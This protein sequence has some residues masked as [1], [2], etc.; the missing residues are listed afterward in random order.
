MLTESCKRL[1]TLAHLENNMGS[2]ASGLI[3]MWRGKD[4][5]TKLDFPVLRRGIFL[6]MLT[7][8]VY[9]TE[10]SALMKFTVTTKWATSFVEAPR[11]FSYITLSTTLK[12]KRIPP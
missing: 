11:I 4:H 7:S 3:E 10:S 12:H 1:C 9:G 8:F 5:E 6:A 2:L